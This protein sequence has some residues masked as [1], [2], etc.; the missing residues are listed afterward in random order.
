[1]IIFSLEDING[2]EK[3]SSITASQFRQQRCQGGTTARPVRRGNGPKVIGRLL[4]GVWILL[5]V[6]ECKTEKVQISIDR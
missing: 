3:A 2:P 5:N 6:R 1:M 4:H